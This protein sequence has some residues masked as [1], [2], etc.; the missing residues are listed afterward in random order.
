M[1][2][3]PLRTEVRRKDD[4]FVPKD[5]VNLV[6]KS[7]NKPANPDCK[8]LCLNFRRYDEVDKTALQYAG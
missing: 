1:G 2:L 4:F 8:A 7:V 5:V 3:S 6:H